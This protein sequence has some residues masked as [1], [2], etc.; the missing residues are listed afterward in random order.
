MKTYLIAGV[1]AV[2][3][4]GG[5]WMLWSGSDSTTPEAEVPVAVADTND[6]L[7]V[8]G[9]FNGSIFDLAKSG[10][11]YKCTLSH[12]IQGVTT[13]GTIY[14]SGS[15]V[16]GDFSSTVPV[17]GTVEMHMISDADFV[18]NW[19]SM[20][21]TGFKAKRTDGGVT[22]GGDALSGQSFDADMVYEYDCVQTP[23]DASLFIVP[24]DIIFKTTG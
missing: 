16:R 9:K 24:T 17:V 12:T 8:D 3:V 10:K 2:V 23:A 1:I 20:M 22:D 14:V 7:V 21:P 19:S 4:L 6:T 13:N 18:Y 5:G 11:S 15:N